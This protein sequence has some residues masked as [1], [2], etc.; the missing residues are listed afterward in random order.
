M[1]KFRR[2]IDK[3]EGHATWTSNSPR[4]SSTTIDERVRRRW[5]TKMIEDNKGEDDWIRNPC[6]L[7]MEA[8]TIIGKLN[9]WSNSA[10]SLVDKL[11]WT[12][13]Q[14]SSDLQRCGGSSGE[15]DE[16]RFNLHLHRSGQS[17]SFPSRSR[18]I[19]ERVQSPSE[20]K[21]ISF[22][23]RKSWAP[24]FSLNYTACNW[25]RRKTSSSWSQ[26]IWSIRSAWKWRF[27]KSIKAMWVKRLPPSQ[28]HRS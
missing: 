23:H 27:F 15:S 1:R 26:M 28:I 18:T 8:E 16:T 17:R 6:Y 4:M 9:T 24:R 14:T 11:S 20:R 10:R 3:L 7:L 25:K 21:S 12:D 22:E 2:S 5:R 13:K 19:D